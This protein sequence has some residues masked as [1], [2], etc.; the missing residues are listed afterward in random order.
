M[1]ETMRRYQSLGAGMAEMKKARDIADA[2]IRY[3]MGDATV[4][5]RDGQIVGSQ[6]TVRNKGY[7]VEPFEYRRLTIKKGI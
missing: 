5:L 6:S 2:E 7:T 3:R 1:L 4:I